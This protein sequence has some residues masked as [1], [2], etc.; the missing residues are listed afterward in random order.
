MTIVYASETLP[1]VAHEPLV[2]LDRDRAVGG[3]VAAEQR[4]ADPVAVTA[5]AELAVELVDEVAAVGEDQDAARPRC[6]DE[7]ER[8]DGLAGSGRVLEPEPAGGVRV[9]GLLRQLDVVVEAVVVLPVLRLLVLVPVLFVLELELGVLLAGDR[10]GRELRRLA[11]AALPLPLPLPLPLR[12][13]SASSA[14]SVPD[15]ASTWWAER[16]VPSTRWGS[17]SESSRSSPSSSENFRRHSID[18]CLAPAS[19]SPRAASSARRL[20]E[21]GASASSSVSP[22]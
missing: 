13:A 7:P 12:W 5:V 11:A 19:T 21:P 18:G 2:G 3:V 16:T 20:A 22:S 4:R 17:S 6:L 8:G 1:G 14:V 10:R 15:S 9:L